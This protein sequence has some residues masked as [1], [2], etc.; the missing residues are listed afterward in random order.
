MPAF[1]PSVAEE[2]GGMLQSETLKRV[3]TNW[4]EGEALFSPHL[5]ITPLDD[6]E[7]SRAWCDIARRSLLSGGDFL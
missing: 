6:V 1:L 2:G 3:Q 7:G 5:F 4:R